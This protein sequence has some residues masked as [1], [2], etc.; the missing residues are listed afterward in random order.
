MANHLNIGKIMALFVK[1]EVKK[2]ILTEIVEYYNNKD[3]SIKQIARQFGISESKALKC[4]VTA[5][6]YP[7]DTAILVKKMR[8]KAMTESEIAES[9]GMTRNAVLSYTPYDRGMQ[10]AEYPSVNALRIRACRAK[11]KGAENG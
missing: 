10:D 2:M 1:R 7:T 4:L 11:K 3:K 9:L 6:I 8:D 5:N